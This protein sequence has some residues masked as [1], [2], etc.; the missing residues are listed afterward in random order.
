MRILNG[1]TNPKGLFM[2]YYNFYYYSNIN[3]YKDNLTK[4]LIKYKYKIKNQK[5]NQ[6]QINQ[7]QINQNKKLEK[8]QK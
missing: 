5:K 7:N 6:N 4:K 3:F 8:N 2:L 1:F